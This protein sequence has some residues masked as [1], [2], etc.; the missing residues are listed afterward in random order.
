MSLIG[1]LTGRVPS[2]EPPAVEAKPEPL[3]TNK[4]CRTDPGAAAD[5][6]RKNS[7]WRFDD[8]PCRRGRAEERS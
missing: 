6:M 1:W 3:P 7:P 8:G 4:R 5:R 2:S